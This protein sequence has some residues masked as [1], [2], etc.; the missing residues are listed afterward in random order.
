MRKLASILLI[1][2]IF[3]APFLVNGQFD[4]VTNS[5]GTSVTITGY[6][7]PPVVVIPQTTNGLYV[8]GIGFDAF[9]GLPITSVVFPDTVTNIGQSAFGS[10]EYLTNVVFSTNTFTVDYNAFGGCGFTSLTIPATM[11]VIGELGAFGGCDS[12]TNLTFGLGVTDIQS[13]DFISCDS[14]PS[15]IIPASVTNIGAY[16]FEDCVDLTNIFFAGDA[17]YVGPA[18]FAL[19]NPPQEGG[20]HVYYIASAYYLPGTTGW[21]EFM[22][23]T[24]LESNVWHNP[25]NISLPLV[26]WNPTI[27]ATGANFGVQEGRYGFD[28][29]GT[30]NLPIAVEACDDLTLSNWVVLE[31]LTLTNGLFHFSEPFQ[32]N[33]PA[34]FYRI[35]F[36]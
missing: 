36:P 2:L 23:E 25:T 31:R 14:L 12:L 30:T 6:S 27:R 8:T 3:T 17:P 18:A 24:F 4:Y 32:T 21:D 15:V 20:V 29:T 34:R 19:F 33:N 13:N 22:S 5:D 35:G 28:I 9:A 1:A 16:D 11:S 7:G 26:L 10:C